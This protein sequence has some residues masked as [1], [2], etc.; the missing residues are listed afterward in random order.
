MFARTT[1]VVVAL[2]GATT[3]LSGHSGKVNKRAEKNTYDYVI[4]G[5]GVS[6]LIVANRLSED[7]K[8]TFAVKSKVE[9]D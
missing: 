7:Q 8:S 5:G 4:V 9:R 6:G 2:L 3:A 1:V